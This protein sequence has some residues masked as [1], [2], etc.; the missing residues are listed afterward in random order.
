MKLYIVTIK[1]KHGLSHNPRNKI[2]GGCPQL[3]GSECSDVTG[4]HHS[5]IHIAEDIDSV[6]KQLNHLRITRIEEARFMNGYTVETERL[7]NT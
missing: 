2:T 6:K 3:W 4:E 5:F 1:V 7:I